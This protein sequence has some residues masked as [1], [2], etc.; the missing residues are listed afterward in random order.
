[1]LRGGHSTA[2]RPWRPAPPAR[3]SRRR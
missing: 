2:G 3:P 1:M